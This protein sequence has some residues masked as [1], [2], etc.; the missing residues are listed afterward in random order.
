MLGILNYLYT[1]VKNM[2][3]SISISSLLYLAKLGDGLD[4]SPTDMVGDK[5]N[6]LDKSRD[7]LKH[8]WPFVETNTHI[9]IRGRT[10]LARYLTRNQ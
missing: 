10:R 6:K 1:P 9:L 7:I 4:E 3:N 5:T 8:S 2:S